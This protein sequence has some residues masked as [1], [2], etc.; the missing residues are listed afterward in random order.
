MTSIKNPASHEEQAYSTRF[1]RC[2]STVERCIGLLKGQF[3]YLLKHRT[4]HY[5]PLTAAII[6]MACAVI[7][8]IALLYNVENPPEILDDID[9][10][11]VPPPLLPSADMMLR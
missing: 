3:W 4:M 11:P 1:V 10:E 9:L 6:I 8:N 2:R 5:M 7:Y